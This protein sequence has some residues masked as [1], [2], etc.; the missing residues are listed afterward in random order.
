[1][2]FWPEEPQRRKAPPKRLKE[3]LYKEQGGR[4]MY[5]GI[6]LA[7]HYFHVDHKSPASRGGG[8]NPAN[9]QLLCGPCNGLKG[10]RYTDGQF[11]KL[12][13]L[14]PARSQSGPPAKQIPRAY[15]DRISKELRKKQQARKRCPDCRST[16]L[17]P[18][19]SL[20]GAFWECQDCGATWP[21]TRREVENLE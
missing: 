8:D 5:C 18:F 14:P 11:R 9:L 21:L 13:G 10:N 16:D 15:F 4:C 3:L 6:R 17:M 2:L 20:I 19:D 1:M 7:I 12:Y